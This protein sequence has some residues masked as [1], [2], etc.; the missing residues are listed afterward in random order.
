MS[1]L[2]IPIDSSRRNSDTSHIFPTTVTALRVFHVDHKAVE[3][4]RPPLQRGNRT[5]AYHETRAG[6]GGKS[7][8]HGQDEVVSLTAVGVQDHTQGREGVTLGAVDD[9]HAD[10]FGVDE[11]GIA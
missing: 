9:L 1:K 4:C 5:V 8:S 10:A 6:F 7:R 3:P 11:T 2:N